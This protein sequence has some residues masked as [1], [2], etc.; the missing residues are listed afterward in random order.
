MADVISAVKS[1]TDCSMRVGLR[2]RVFEGTRLR[3]DDTGGCTLKFGPQWLSGVGVMPSLLVAIHLPAINLMYI[4]FAAR[5]MDVTNR[6]RS[7]V[8]WLRPI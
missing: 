5:F 1:E 6:G 3:R 2:R 8:K 4:I 7:H